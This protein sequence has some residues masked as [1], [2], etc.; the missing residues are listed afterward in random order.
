L[1]NGFSLSPATLIWYWVEIRQQ[2]VKKQIRRKTG[3]PDAQKYVEVLKQ[4]EI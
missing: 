3:F 2:Y 4:N 1:Q